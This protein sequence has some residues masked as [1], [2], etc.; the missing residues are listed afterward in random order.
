MPSWL[1]DGNIPQPGDD[2]WRTHVKIASLLFAARGNKGP[3]YYPEGSEPQPG[4][5]TQRLKEKIDAMLS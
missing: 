4:D 1:P 5:T 3:A 2:K